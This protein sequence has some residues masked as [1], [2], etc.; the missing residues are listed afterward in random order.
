V[1]K[2]LDNTQVI[3][4]DPLP[5][6]LYLGVGL[7]QSI[8]NRPSFYH[9]HAI[10]DTPTWCGQGFNPRCTTEIWGFRVTN[11]RWATRESTISSAQHRR[12][13]SGLVFHN[14]TSAL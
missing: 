2:A 6:N 11:W 8:P 7:E 12:R 1:S 13:N 10:L 5:L 14:T 3:G 9:A 4:L